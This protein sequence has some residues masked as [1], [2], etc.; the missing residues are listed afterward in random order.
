MQIQGSENMHNAREAISFGLG[1]I[2]GI[3]I[4]IPKKFFPTGDK[5][6]NLLRFY[7]T[8]PQEQMHA[9]RAHP[10]LMRSI[11]KVSFILTIGDLFPVNKHPTTQ[12]QL[13]FFKI[14]L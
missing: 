2:I 14:N 7:P 12:L 4:Y 9:C 6:R 10:Q 5:L 11:P 3:L 8:N 1:Y 13:G